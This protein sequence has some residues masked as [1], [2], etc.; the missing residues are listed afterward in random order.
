MSGSIVLC[1][2]QQSIQCIPLSLLPCLNI[3]VLLTTPS[4]YPSPLSLLA[5]FPPYFV[6]LPPPHIPPSSPFPLLFRSYLPLLISHHNQLLPLLPPFSPEYF[7]LTRSHKQT[8]THTNTHIHR[9]NKTQ[10]CLYALTKPK[11][12]R[13]RT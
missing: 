1:R 11:S 5:S 8:H 3:I 10:Y 4:G 7:N 13:K 9:H 12:Y 2:Q 6:H